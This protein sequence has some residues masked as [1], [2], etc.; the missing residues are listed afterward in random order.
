NAVAFWT[1]GLAVK[2]E[3]GVRHAGRRQRDKEEACE[4]PWL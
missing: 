1:W 3:T 4:E 2:K